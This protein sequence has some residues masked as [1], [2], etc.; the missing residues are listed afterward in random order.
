MRDY[1]II[2]GKSWWNVVTALGVVVAVV[3]GVSGLAIPSV[4][5]IALF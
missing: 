4:A 1:F 5:W 3:T 2:V